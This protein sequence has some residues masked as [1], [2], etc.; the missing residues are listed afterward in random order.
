M[1]FAEPGVRAWAIENALMW[2]RDYRLDGL[3]LDAVFA[4]HDDTEEHVLAELARRVHEENPNALVIAE[5]ETGSL[6]PIE[7]WSHDAQRADEFHH[8]LHVALTGEREGYCARYDGTPSAIA[9]QLEREPAPRLVY[10]SQN[11]DQVGNRPAGDRP[12]TDELRIRDALMLFA[13]QTP[14][15]FQGEE[16]GERRPFQ[17]F[18]DHVDPFFAEA[19]REGRRRECDAFPGFSA[20]ELPDPQAEETFERSKLDPSAGDP[21][22][23]AFYRRL[24]EL[25]RALPREIQTEADDESGTLRLTRGPVT[26]TV[27][28]PNRTVELAG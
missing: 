24:L 10:C 11:H 17:Y 27:G 4:I 1:N 5:M 2:I 12:A 18:T 7:E 8:E 21:E 9:G 22:L 6:R 25:R 16:Y 13:T 20:D 15:L 26:L 23:R 3:R 14:L 28:F 19:T